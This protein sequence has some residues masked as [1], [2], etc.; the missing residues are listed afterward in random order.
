MGRLRSV[1]RGDCFQ[2]GDGLG[3]RGRRRRTSRSGRS[4]SARGAAFPLTLPPSRASRRW[5]PCSRV[6]GG[7]TRTS[8]R[9]SVVD[10]PSGDVIATAAHCLS[11][12]AKDLEFV[13]M[14]HDG[15]APYGAVERD[16]RL[17]QPALDAA[18]GSA[19]GFR[20]PDRQPAARRRKG[21][22]GAERRGR[23]PA[24]HRAARPRGG[25]SWSGTPR[26]AAVSRSSASTRPSPGHGY[27]AFRCG[28]FVG[29]TSGGPWLAD[30]NTQT[31][32]GDLYGVTGGRHQGGCV[33][34]V[35]YSSSFNADTMAVYE[36]AVAGQ[37]PDVIPAAAASAVL[38]LLLRTAVGPG[39]AYAGLAPVRRRML[40]IVGYSRRLGTRVEMPG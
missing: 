4:W 21:A 6:H 20:L 7:A 10:S 38:I 12:N 11:G 8:A 31:G 30:Y 18:P 9:A 23:R 14:Y 27:P 39:L 2:P 35:S 34:W 40:A 17:R 37:P 33:N 15:Q 5:V 13:P 24:G 28:G 19:G 29:G 32:R 36:R 16:R 3:R 25:P 22:H 1:P 26:A